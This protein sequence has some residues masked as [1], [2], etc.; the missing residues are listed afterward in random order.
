MRGR[1]GQQKKASERFFLSRRASF[2][3]LSRHPIPSPTA[4]VE[5]FRVRFV[6]PVTGKSSK[7]VLGDWKARSRR[8]RWKEKN[9]R[10][11][12]LL[13]TL[14]PGT[15]TLRSVELLHVSSPLC[16]N[17]ANPEA[18]EEGATSREE[19]GEREGRVCIVGAPHG[20]EESNALLLSLLSA[21]AGAAATGGLCMLAPG[22]MVGWPRRRREKGKGA[23]PPLASLSKFRV[24]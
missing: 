7:S 10:P 18:S 2:Q 20:L 19:A 1:E 3:S 4:P 6:F 5:G 16:V 9:P 12:S 22:A 17:L 24:E 11:L 8:G 13:S 21:A 23:H 15:S 14:L